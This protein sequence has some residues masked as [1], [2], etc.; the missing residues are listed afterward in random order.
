MGPP[1]K[2]VA[3]LAWLIVSSVCSH[4]IQGQIFQGLNLV[5]TNYFAKKKLC[6]SSLTFMKDSEKTASFICLFCGHVG[7]LVPS[8]CIGVF[9]FAFVVVRAY[10]IWYILLKNCLISLSFRWRVCLVCSRVS[11]DFVIFFRTLPSFLTI[12]S[13][14]MVKQEMGNVFFNVL[15]SDP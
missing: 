2:R 5:V 15:D 7:F 12:G 1:P 10:R 4:K 14:L 11:L 9:L 8:L 13:T 3:S 6:N